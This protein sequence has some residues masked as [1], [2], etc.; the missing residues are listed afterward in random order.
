MKNVERRA[1]KI[2]WMKVI[3]ALYILIHHYFCLY[4]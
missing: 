1:E 4:H 2:N 3:E